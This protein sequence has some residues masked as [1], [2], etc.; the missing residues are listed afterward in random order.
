MT[1]EVNAKG[2]WNAVSRNAYKGITTI[3]AK[4]YAKGRY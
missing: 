3:R 1:R 4:I 2:W